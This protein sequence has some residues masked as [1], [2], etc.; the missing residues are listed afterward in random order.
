MAKKRKCD[1]PI[2]RTLSAKS[3][4]GMIKPKPAKGR[5]KLETTKVSK[6]KHSVRTSTSS[7]S[8]KKEIVAL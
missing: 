8:K 4:Q 5:A 7:P 2:M 1:E 3:G 6:K